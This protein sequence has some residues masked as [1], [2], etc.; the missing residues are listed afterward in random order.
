MGLVR[1]VTLG[2]KI[3]RSAR[4][5][6]EL[7]TLIMVTRACKSARMDFMAILLITSAKPVMKDAE[8]ARLPLTNHAQPAETSWEQASHTT[9]NSVQLTVHCNVQTESIKF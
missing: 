8:N 3:A 4:T 2:L 6:L 9:S 5:T 7:F 1:F